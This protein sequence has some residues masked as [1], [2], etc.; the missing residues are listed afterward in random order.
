M[1]SLTQYQT[2]DKEASI[3]SKIYS[4][5]DQYRRYYTIKEY[6][7]NEY[8]INFVSPKIYL[9]E[10]FRFFLL[11]NSETK[12]LKVEHY[13][14]P[15]YVSYEEYK[16]IN[17]WALLLFINDIPTIEDFDVETIKV[18]TKKAITKLTDA[19]PRRKTL[20]EIVPLHRLP[21][22]PT[23]PLF[24]LKK[25]I[26]PKMET[27]KVS[28]HMPI[29]VYFK[30]E[31]YTISL[32]DARKRY[33]DLSEQPVRESLVLKIENDVNF[34]FDKHFSIIKG[35]NGFNRL[36]WDP[37]KIKNGVGLINK[38]VEGTNIEVSYAKRVK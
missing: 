26:P 36:T 6:S 14:R 19:A 2:I 4:D 20:Q 30:R 8:L 29:D 10:E 13:Y 27:K 21:L 25:Y 31:N 32:I 17:Y 5:L 18:P 22:K 3:L 37:R 9:F 34:L 33:I 1:G 15:D 16:T 38:L 35:S 28:H 11:Y 12:P 23:D 24:S 7:D